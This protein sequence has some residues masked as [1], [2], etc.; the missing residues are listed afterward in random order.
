M[1]GSHAL[2]TRGDVRV[3]CSGD[4][5]RCQGHMLWRSEEMSGSQALETRD[6]RSHALVVLRVLVCDFWNTS[7]MDSQSLGSG[8][9]DTET[10]IWLSPH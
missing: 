8:F 7:V 3:I 1:S 4:Q 9:L 10:D 5:R 2:E 6:V